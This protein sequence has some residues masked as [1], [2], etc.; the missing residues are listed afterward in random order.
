MKTRIFFACFVFC[1]A[2]QAN[3][4]IEFAP[5]GAEW[6]Y[7]Y[8]FGCC[9]EN[10]FNHIISE[11][12][13]II[14]G[15]NCRVLRQ[16]YN[17]S[18]TASEKFIIKQEQGKVYYYYQDKFNL[19]FDFD[20]EVNDIVE[21]SFM[22]SDTVLSA[23]YHV[24]DIS[25]NAQN[26][27]TFTTKFIDIDNYEPKHG[28]VYAY[29]ND[30]TIIS[31]VGEG[32]QLVSNDVTLNDALNDFNVFSFKYAFPLASSAYL[33]RIVVMECNCNAKG[34][35]DFLKE[36]FLIYFSD[37]EYYGQT[38]YP[39]IG[40]YS[41]CF[42]Y[43]VPLTYAYTE[44]IGSF[45]EFMPRFNSWDIPDIEVYLFLKSYSDVD[46]CLAS[47]ICTD[48]FQFSC[49]YPIASDYFSPCNKV[50]INSLKDNNIKIY[51]NP[52][53]D[54]FFVFTNTRGNIEI[55]DISGKI[56]YYSELSNGINEIS[57]NHFLKGIYLVKIQDKDNGIQLFKIVK[58]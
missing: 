49:S 2:W 24:E 37:I 46:L 30:P 42:P 58:L 12:D 19:L 56:V 10:H 23:R 43:R 6:Y 40:N 36:N 41:Q 28:Y 26:L 1:F 17:N 16:Y 47:K 38:M 25:I 32:E 15:S 34:L 33:R 22:Y 55:V 57:T 45:V 31:Y 48:N 50:N 27:K 3:A 54:N 44:K 13:T 52:F 18:N 21:F 39:Q 20:A 9:P 11:K 4:Q 7:T 53:S 51:P 14:E 35:A 8:T 5:M 29:I